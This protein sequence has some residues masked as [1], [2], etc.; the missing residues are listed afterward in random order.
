MEVLRSHLNNFKE[1]MREDMHTLSIHTQ[2]ALGNSKLKH[3]EFELDVTR[4]ANEHQEQLK[5]LEESMKGYMGDMCDVKVRIGEIE[6][7][8]LADEDKGKTEDVSSIFEELKEGLA[9]LAQELDEHIFHDADDIRD[10][11]FSIEERFT[12]LEEAHT[13]ECKRLL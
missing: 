3:A 2:A 9:R 1:E 12:N 7:K 5:G 4:L 8:V 10:G 6:G 11:H 13:E